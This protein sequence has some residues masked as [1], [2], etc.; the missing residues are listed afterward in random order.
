MLAPNIQLMAEKEATGMTKDLISLRIGLG[1]YRK[2]D[3]IKKAGMWNWHM[4]ALG[5]PPREAWHNTIKNM[6]ITFEL[7]IQYFYS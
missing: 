6:A 7:S 2:S 5:T 1:L 4:I 3:I